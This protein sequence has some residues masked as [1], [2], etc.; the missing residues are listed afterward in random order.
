MKK[1]IILL[2]LAVCAVNGMAQQKQKK[3]PAE[4]GETTPIKPF[5]GDP[6]KDN[7]AIYPFTSV[8]G[9]DY[10]YAESVGNAVEAGFVRSTRF[11][12]LERNRFAAIKNEERF[13]EVNTDN[14]VKIA[15][16]LGAKYIITG[17]ITGVSIGQLYNSYDH[18]FSG[19]QASISLAFKIIEVETGLIKTSESI[20]IAGTGGSEAIAKGN[21]YASID[22][23]TR[24]LIA[25]NFPQRFKFNA[26][27]KTDIKKKIE[28]LT[29]FKFW[30]GSE[31]GIKVGDWVQVSVLSYTI[32]PSTNKKVEEKS[33]IGFGSVTEI[34]SGS[35]A[36]CE[37]YK[38]NK[39]GAQLL[40]TVTKTPD[41][42]IVE[43]SGGQKPKN[44]FGF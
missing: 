11:N 35:T 24:N 8:S 31:N 14:V 2:L 22:A 40:E 17:Q 18:S 4:P 34:N 38:P 1:I 30:G 10:T 39:Y 5:V 42:V 7:V 26:V 33:N 36:T 44:F 37:V 32:N 29:H 21:A 9:L 16:K 6:N 15:A 43:Y 20:N 41:L 25:Q 13:K 12:V 19:Y 23:I 28:V 3:K 27:A